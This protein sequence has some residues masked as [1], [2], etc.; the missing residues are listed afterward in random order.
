MAAIEAQAK[1]ASSL[2]LVPQDK[3]TIRLL[4]QSIRV[5][6]KITGL[7]R[8]EK[9]IDWRRVSGVPV[10]EEDERKSAVAFVSDPRFVDS[11]RSILRLSLSKRAAALCSYTRSDAGMDRKQV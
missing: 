10:R 11:S 7:K 9:V 4:H 2:A 3:Q 8:D 6:E 5:R 1:T